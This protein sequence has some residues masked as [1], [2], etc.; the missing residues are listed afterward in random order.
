MKFEIY[1]FKEVTSTNDI[2]VNLI[3][4]KK[5]VTG[6]VYSDSQ[7]KGRGTKGKKWI[8]LKGN[9]FTSLFFP[10]KDKYPPFNEFSIIN[11]ILI[12]DVIKKFCNDKNIT[13]KYPND[14]F[15]N[16]KKICGVLQELIV[17]EDRKFLIIGIGLNIISNP[18]IEKKYKAT[19][20]LSETKSAPEIKE[21]IDLIILSYERFFMELESYNFIKFRK[22]AELMSLN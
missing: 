2:A 19:N 18:N 20:I 22:K 5:K 11:P 3:K 9:L 7:T 21:I 1:K 13:L 6:C 17:M 16:G 8:S 12:A 4:E 15:L 14:V 10:L